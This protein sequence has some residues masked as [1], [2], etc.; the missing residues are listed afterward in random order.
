MSAFDDMRW[1]LMD[2]SPRIVGRAARALGTH[3]REVA[4]CATDARALGFR[5][6]SFDLVLSTSTLDHFAEERDIGTAVGAI[7]E[8]L[9]PGGR[10]LITLDNPTNLVL[11]LRQLIHHLTGPLGG[12][13]PFPMGR[14]MPARRLVS[15]LERQGFHV[16]ESGYLLHAPRL[17][18][19]WI[20][21]WA[22][23]CGFRQLGDWLRRL[24][25][26]A[27][28][29]LSHL[30]T[31]RWTGHFVVADC[32]RCGV[33]GDRSRGAGEVP[34]LVTRFHALEHRLR[35]GY[36]RAVP[37]R[38]L[39]R[40]DPPLN[41]AATFVRRTLATPLYLAQELALWSGPC[42]DG[43]GKIVSWGRR[44]DVK[45]LVD[46]FLDGEPRVSR[47]GIRTFPARARARGG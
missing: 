21:E 22:A 37:P 9:R 34:R 30:P 41:G 36:L 13:I 4:H 7:H 2:V 25:G 12:L 32:R 39:A 44:T 31:R 43:A 28:V 42:G 19:L 6:G 10:L 29:V 3:G 45:R 24:F 11:R 5:S 26:T 16:L 14:T 38:L 8:V 18:G 27:E 33:R 40:I 1:V 15:L 20:G 23:R 46:L 17:L 47:H 35:C